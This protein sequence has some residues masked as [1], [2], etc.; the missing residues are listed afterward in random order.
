MNVAATGGAAARAAAER[1]TQ[2]NIR[3]PAGRMGMTFPLN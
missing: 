3:V 2:Q 1:K